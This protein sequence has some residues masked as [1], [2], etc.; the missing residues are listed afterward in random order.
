MLRQ[1]AEQKVSRAFILTSNPFEKKQTKQGQLN[2]S[3][4]ARPNLTV[5]LAPVF[6]PEDK[7]SPNM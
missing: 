5:G 3:Y 6:V 2:C 1:A 4:F 7:I